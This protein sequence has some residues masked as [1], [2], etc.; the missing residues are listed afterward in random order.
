[1]KLNL[2]NLR[3]LILKKNKLKISATVT[4]KK[5]VLDP[6]GKVVS[7][8][9]KNMG[10]KSIV[11]VRQGKYFEIELLHDKYIKK[12]QDEFRK[13]KQ[14]FTHVDDDRRTL[15]GDIVKQSENRDAIMQENYSN[16]SLKKKLV[17]LINWTPQ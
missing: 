12:A 14:F 17:P 11:N 7:Q 16:I 4:L 3:Q 15:S 1:M 9:L 5:D 2:A 6:Q 10:Y 8:T 13:E